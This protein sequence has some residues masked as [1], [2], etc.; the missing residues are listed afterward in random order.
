MV[1]MTGRLKL[2]NWKRIVILKRLIEW[3][4]ADG[5][6]DLADEWQKE[7]EELQEIENKKRASTTANS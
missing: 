6:H 7:M 5:H 4:R 3:T 1:K 2:E